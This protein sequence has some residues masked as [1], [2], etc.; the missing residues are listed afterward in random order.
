MARSHQKKSPF[1]TSTKGPLMSDMWE[2]A[3]GFEKEGKEYYERLAKESSIEE[4]SG[5]FSIL[6]AEEQ[7]HY[8]LFDKL[9]KGQQ[10]EAEN[11]GALGSAKEAFARLSKDNDMPEV[12]EDA[13]SVYRKALTLENS[14]IKFY[15]EALVK[16]EDAE[17]KSIVTDVLDQ[18]R[19]HAR[20]ISGMIE[21][22]GRPKEWLENAEWHH[23]DEY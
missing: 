4:L 17:Q 16:L 19:S 3:K 5:V 18:E 15:E 1:R 20:I 10:A 21:F 11:S 23:L 14:S 12:I 22:I 8:D 2:F 9:Q 13:E 7:R 6:A